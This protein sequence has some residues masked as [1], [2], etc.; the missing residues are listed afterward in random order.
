[1]FPITVTRGGKIKGK[2]VVLPL[3]QNRSR[4]PKERANFPPF[5]WETRDNTQAS[6]RT[7]AKGRLEA[8]KG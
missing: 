7:A 4:T 2:S 5:N 1:M 3:C 6:L 8:A